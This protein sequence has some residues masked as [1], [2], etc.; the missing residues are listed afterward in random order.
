M[1]VGVLVMFGTI[2]I[3]SLG[4]VHPHEQKKVLVG[5]V[6]MIATTSL[7]IS[8]LSVIVSILYICMKNLERLKRV[9]FIIFNY[10][11]CY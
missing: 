6:G 11:L 4:V 7:H 9:D 2:A 10:C 3:I 8:P 5:S 1:L